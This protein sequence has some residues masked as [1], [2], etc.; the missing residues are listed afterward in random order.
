MQLADLVLWPV[1][2]DGYNP[3]H[4]AYADLIGAGKLLDVQCTPENGLL[5]VK[6]SCFDCVP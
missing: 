6:Y 4:R 5:G 3:N 1:C 2:H